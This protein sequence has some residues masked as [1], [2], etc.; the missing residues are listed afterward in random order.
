MSNLPMPEN[1]SPLDARP[2][3]QLHAC[4]AHWRPHGQNS[5]HTLGWQTAAQ[6]NEETWFLSVS[7]PSGT[8]ALWI[9]ARDLKFINIK[10]LHDGSASQMA[11]WDVC[12]TVWRLVTPLML[13][14]IL[15][16]TQLLTC[17]VVKE[18]IDGSQLRRQPCGIPLENWRSLLSQLSK[19]FTIFLNIA[20]SREK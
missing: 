15:S 10:L 12:L 2:Q 16:S 8:W 7:V 3:D 5:A 20:K 11:C 13:L 18:N 17:Q 14:S 19:C 9:Q 1:I 4:S 6:L